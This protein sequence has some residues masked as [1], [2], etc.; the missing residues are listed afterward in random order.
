MFLDITSLR[1]YSFSVARGGLLRAGSDLNI[2]QPLEPELGNASGGKRHGRSMFLRFV[3]EGSFLSR[4]SF[5]KESGFFVSGKRKDVKMT[6]NDGIKPIEPQGR[7]LGGM[8]FFLLW[9]GA[10][11]SLAEIWAG[12]LLVP[13]GFA[14]GFLLFIGSVF[15]PLFGVVLADYFFLRRK[16]IFQ[17]RHGPQKNLLVPGGL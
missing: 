17:A 10:A 3:F 15:C 13:M 11:V 4:F 14:T 16:N 8:D 9:A 1:R 7:N 5:M 6:G 12:G 2:L